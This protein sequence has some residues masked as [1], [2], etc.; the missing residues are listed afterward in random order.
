VNTLC[1]YLHT[2]LLTRPYSQVVKLNESTS[3]LLWEVEEEKKKKNWI[4][5]VF[6]SEQMNQITNAE[7]SQ[8]FC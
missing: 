8:S 1:K 5:H 7:D 4:I 3:F 2:D 6:L